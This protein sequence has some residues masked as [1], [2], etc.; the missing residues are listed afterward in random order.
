M[1]AN[2]HRLVMESPDEA[3]ALLDEQDAEI[4]RLLV[5][6]ADKQAYIERIDRWHEAGER[7][8]LRAR[9]GWRFQAGEWWA[10]RPWRKRRA[11]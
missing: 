4:E 5:A 11:P 6:L 3:I 9:T 10:D 8:I 2:H 1:R 7:I